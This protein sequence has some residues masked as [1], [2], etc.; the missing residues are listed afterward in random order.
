MALQAPQDEDV[1]DDADPPCYLVRPSDNV[2][3]FFMFIG[4]TESKKKNTD[5][6]TFDIV[7]AYVL[8]AMNFFMQ[9]VLVW[10]VFEEVVLSNLDWQN[11]ILKLEGGA[12]GDLFAEPASECNTGGA[13]CFV[14]PSG[15]Y[16]C[17]PPS[18]QLVGRWDELDTNKDGIWT[19]DEVKASRE[20]LMCKYVVDPQEV[21]MVLVE[22]LKLRENLIWLHPDVKAGKAIHQ[23]YF[24]YILGDLV[25]CGYRSEDMCSNLMERGFFDK[26][27][28]HNTAPRVG[29]TIESAL[30]YCRT[31][32]QP[33]GTCETLLPS[34]Y[35]TWKVQSQAECGSPSYSKFTYTNPG[36]Q[37]TKSLLSVG[38]GAPEEYT[39][40]QQPH[41]R[42]FK[43]IILFIWLLLMFCEFKEV[44]KILTV[45]LRYPDAAE[46]G[47]DAV[48][49][50]QDPSDPEDVRYRIQGI[51]KNHRR[52]MGILCILRTFVT[53]ALMFVGMSYIIKTN[54]YVDLLMNGVTLLFVA[55][56]SNILYSQ[57]LREEIRDQTEDIKAMKVPMYGWEWLNRRPALLDMSCV[58]F[59]VG[60]VYMVMWWNLENV[61]LPIYNALECTCLS[62]GDQC[63]E[64]KEFDKPWWDNYWFKVIPGVFSEVDALK[65]TVPGAA[66]Y[67]ATNSN[68]MDQ[69]QALAY[70]QQLEAQVEKMATGNIEM[71]KWIDTMTAQLATMPDQPATSDTAEITPKTKSTTVAPPAMTTTKSVN[72]TT[73]GNVNKTMGGKLNSSSLIEKKRALKH[74]KGSQRSMHHNLQ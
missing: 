36:T 60:V 29:T 39:L 40:A 61:T 55:D 22:M 28:K 13:L 62:S 12:M 15:V 48:L 21:F 19:W 69:S 52:V 23:T 31:L 49:M 20:S 45:V 5:K 65:A 47:E 71:Q 8:V 51:T 66:F 56:V 74:I 68:A 10:L 4:P 37:V 64:A 26:P 63:F 43:A 35:A 50:E 53:V 2:Y 33:G 9:A 57:I 42:V 7:M 32:L 1:V 18:I 6:C 11:G 41:F 67:A 34:T 59:L 73:Q 3:S 27:L 72:A 44:W 46:F 58:L 16:T 30:R 38:Y 54:G 14:D 25:M 17:S 70:H 24:Q